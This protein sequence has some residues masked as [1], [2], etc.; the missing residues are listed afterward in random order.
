[1][2]RLASQAGWCMWS[3][4]RPYS[5]QLF[6]AFV[7]MYHFFQRVHHA[8]TMSAVAAQ[9]H[10]ASTLFHYLGVLAL[11][12]IIFFVHRDIWHRGIQGEVGVRTIHRRELIG[13][14]IATIAIVIAFVLELIADGIELNAV[15]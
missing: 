10:L 3:R 13:T 11:V 14:I 5:R 8:H 12:A 1:M 9:L 6:A 7:Y 2:P 4:T 15:D